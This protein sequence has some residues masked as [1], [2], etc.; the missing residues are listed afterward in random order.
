MSGDV[1]RGAPRRRVVL[2][3]RGEAS[4]LFMQEAKQAEGA[5]FL[6]SVQQLGFSL[7]QN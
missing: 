2:L 3:S 6:L 5:R 7:L 4:L 1:V